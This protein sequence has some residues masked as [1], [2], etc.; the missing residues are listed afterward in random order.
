[1]KGALG[2][3]KI[4]DELI[5]AFVLLLKSMQ[6][7]SRAVDQESVYCLYFVIVA[8]CEMVNERSL[9][10]SNL[11]GTRRKS[12]ANSSACDFQEA[13][14]LYREEMDVDWKCLKAYVGLKKVRNAL[15][16]FPSQA[17]KIY[18]H[19]VLRECSF[20]GDSTSDWTA[21]N[22]YYDFLLYCV[23]ETSGEEWSEFL[24]ESSLDVDRVRDIIYTFCYEIALKCN[25][26]SVH[27]G[28]RKMNFAS[29]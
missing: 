8:S 16:H 6:R 24:E 15:V 5:R 14:N 27:N 18:E 13:N 3:K 2:L 23:E 10:E 26:L 19:L 28:L 12:A 20:K 4:D 7:F 25:K 29:V 11:C 1:M 22:N 21:L 9:K 17:T